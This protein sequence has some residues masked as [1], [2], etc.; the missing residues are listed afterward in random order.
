[1]EYLFETGAG[2][3]VGI[4]GV[5]RR[6]GNYGDGENNDTQGPEKSRAAAVFHDASDYHFRRGL[7]MAGRW[8]FEGIEAKVPGSHGA[9]RLRSVPSIQLKPGRKDQ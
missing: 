9:G 3:R 8:S 1:L 7:K 5:R 4:F 2:V 6:T